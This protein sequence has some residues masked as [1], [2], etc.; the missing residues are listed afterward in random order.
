MAQCF[1]L[2][3]LLGQP[4]VVTP[5]PAT[6]CYT[7]AKHLLLHLG[8]PPVVTPWP[9]TC[10]YTLAS[11]LLLHL[12]QP[13]VVT[14]WPATCCYTLAS[15]LLLH[16]GQPPVVTPWPATCCY[17]LA[18]HLLLHLGQPPVVTPWPATCCYTLASHLLLHLHIEMLH[19]KEVQTDYPHFLDFVILNSDFNT[20]SSTPACTVFKGGRPAKAVWEHFV[21]VESTGKNS[22]STQVLWSPDVTQM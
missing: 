22:C 19:V 9:A 10:C 12:G 17:T 7:L 1:L 15:H 16:L 21:K 20:A 3:K 4:P 8:Q 14:P 11:H 13:P 2:S 6:C 18:S 5:W